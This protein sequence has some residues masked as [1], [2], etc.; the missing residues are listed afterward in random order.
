MGEIGK[1]LKKIRLQHNLTQKQMG[2]EVGL[3]VSTI[4][5]IEQGKSTTTESL[6]RI[7]S[8]LNRIKDLESVF[9]VGEN[10]ELKLKFEKARLKTERK[11]ASKKIK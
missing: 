3:S 1:R 11:R 6:L 9:R 5:L 7:L 10:L 2:E 8:R 4:S